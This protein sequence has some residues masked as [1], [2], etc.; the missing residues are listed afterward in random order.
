VKFRTTVLLSG[1]TATGLPVPPEV[2]ESLGAGKRVPVQVTIGAHTYRSTVA[3]YGGQ[4]M[5][6]LS[7]EHR[8]SAGVTPGQDVEVEI[9][10]D[11]APREVE[12]PADFAAVLKKD[13]AARKAFEALSYS[14]QRRHVLAIEGAKTDETR[15]RR[16]AKA[17]AELQGA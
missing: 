16:I 2:V 11:S 3:P 7:A 14:N 1:K 12:V 13:A 15:Q 5:I 8:E 4:Y 9:T 6:P 17:L 10:V